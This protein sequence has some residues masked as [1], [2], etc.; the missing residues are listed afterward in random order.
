MTARLCTKQETHSRSP[1]FGI[2]L[3]ESCEDSPLACRLCV[4]QHHQGH[5]IVSLDYLEKS[6]QKPE[7]PPKLNT[8][9]SKYDK[10]GGQLQ[11][12]V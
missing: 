5:L 4:K 10:E 2:C 1:I 6:Y 8:L 12:Q 3:E 7:V 11:K 9:I